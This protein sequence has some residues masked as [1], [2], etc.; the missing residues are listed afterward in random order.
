MDPVSF[1]SS[2]LSLIN[3]AKKIADYVKDIK[4]GPKE[5]TELNKAVT[6]IVKLLDL[7]KD[8]FE[9]TPTDD[10]CFSAARQMA[11]EDRTFD[12]LRILLENLEKKLRPADGKV[13][14]ALQ[15]VVT[16]PLLDKADVTDLLSKVKHL[17]T[18]I[19]LAL[20]G[21]HMYVYELF[22]AGPL[23]P[24]MAGGSIQTYTV[25]HYAIDPDLHCQ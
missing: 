17:K 14:R 23:H 2:I 24:I 9:E 13:R 4:D 11:E 1:A 15:T 19:G 21:D 5:C 10:L 22:P 8:Q 7:L 12:Q 18:L 20:Q 25:G 6:A 3:T 16:W